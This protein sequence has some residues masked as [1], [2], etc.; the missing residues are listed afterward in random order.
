MCGIAGFNWADRIL[1]NK[2]ADSISHRGP[3]DSGVH[4]D[5]FVSL[6][7]RRLSIIDLSKNGHQPMY[8]ENR[9]IAVVFNGEIWNY[10][11][12]KE[13]LER[14]GHK[15]R[16]Q[17]DTEIIVHG[18]EE[19]GE[20]IFEKMDGMFAIALWDMRKK[21]LILARD[22]IGKKPLYYYFRGGK[23]IFAS[24]IKAILE[25]K[26]ERKINKQCLADFL[27]LRFSPNE[28]TMFDGIR[29]VMPGSFM[30]YQDK[31]IKNIKYWNLPEF[32][33]IFKP[34]V[35]KSEELITEAVRKRM[36]SDVP[37]GVFLSGGLDSSSIVAYMSKFASNIKTFSIGF[38]DNTDETK[39]ARIIAEKYGTEHNEIK[40]DMNSLSALPK[41]VWHFDEP[42]ADPAALPTY[43]LC[44]KVSQKVKV[45]LS[46]EGGDEVFGG[47]DTFNYIDKIKSLKRYPL[48]L[49]KNVLAKMAKLSSGLF[50]YPKKQIL[51]LASEILE[52][53]E[54]EKKAYKKLFYFPF[55][56]ESKKMI[57]TGEGKLDL[58]SPVD[59]ILKEAVDIYEGTMRYYFEEWL[60]NDLLMK[61]DKMS[62]AHGL[63]IRT[64]FLDVRL[65]EYYAGISYKNKKNRKLFRETI[66]DK[67]PDEIMRRRKQG[68]TLPL[69]NWTRNKEFIEKIRPYIADLA[70][71]KIL[72]EKEL[73]KIVD[74]PTDFRNDHKLWVL[75]NLEIWCKIYLDKTDY[76]EIKL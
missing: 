64:P 55:D 44:E 16:S 28:E 63:E 67:I 20:D 62:M 10:A 26:I 40:L 46:G 41:I 24:E 6:G 65:I 8:N 50:R 31:K 69:S 19:Y 42:L 22:K 17:S 15:F 45:A 75:L 59:L 25:H 11:Y 38:G 51:A 13:E 36:I 60:P 57:I 56:K 3:D 29:K 48:F 70:K 18:Y 9:R 34:E 39:Y 74:N 53:S 32:K 52:C 27:E 68:F 23:L 33:E 1:I 12:I 14:N 35:S 54:D 47:Y 72:N 71:R 5:S 66:K 73:K 37:I 76:K 30:V 4:V 21:K 7:H 49:R 58:E 43:L 61:A 2:M